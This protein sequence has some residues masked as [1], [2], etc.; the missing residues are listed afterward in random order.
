MGA[1]AVVSVLLGTKLVDRR[2]L[3]SGRVA[4]RRLRLGL[5]GFGSGAG[6]LVPSFFCGGSVCGVWRM[7]WGR[8]RCGGKRRRGMGALGGGVLVW[9][10][11]IRGWRG[12]IECRGAVWGVVSLGFWGR[13]L[14]RG[15]GR[16]KSIA[17]RGLVVDA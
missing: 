5:V 15:C 4:P 2:L 12:G 14:R 9:I 17:I 3:S 7:C 16:D 1:G 13:G 11:R 8:G 6:L 10:V